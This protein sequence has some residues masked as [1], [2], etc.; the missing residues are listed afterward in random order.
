MHSP[1]L[2][3]EPYLDTPMAGTAGAA[4]EDGASNVR[5]QVATVT[6]PKTLDAAALEKDLLR[7]YYENADRSVPQPCVNTLP[8]ADLESVRSLLTL[9]ARFSSLKIGP[10]AV[11]QINAVLA[12]STL[13][14]RPMYIVAG[15][16]R[17]SER[18]ARESA[19]DMKIVKAIATARILPCAT[20]DAMNIL[21]RLQPSP[22]QS[23]PRKKPELSE[24]SRKWA[25]QMD[26]QDAA[27]AAYDF[28]GE[29]ALLAKEAPEP[30]KTTGLR[31]AW[32]KLTRMVGWLS[33]A[34]AR[35]EA[36]LKREAE[37]RRAQR[38]KIVPSP[39]RM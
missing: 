38:L 1:D 25:A 28:A 6:K 34:E 35:Y 29:Y 20:Q 21:A 24:A 27:F 12:A 36:R 19:E 15:H 17:D 9:K 18:D 37:L 33:E 16:M 2:L 3:S 32:G 4:V 26:A 39:H 5:A 8:S 13:A 11:T 14:P 7:Y 23:L 22:A 31:W 10:D 30:P